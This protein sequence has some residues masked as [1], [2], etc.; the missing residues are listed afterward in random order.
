VKPTTFDEALD[1]V[2]EELPVETLDADIA[3]YGSR[4]R[5]AARESS[6]WDVF[7]LTHHDDLDGYYHA[8]EKRVVIKERGLD[9]LFVD[10]QVT[11]KRGW[12]RRELAAALLD[13]RWVPP[14]HPRR[15]K[16]DWDGLIAER[17]SRCQ[18]LA[19]DLGRWWSKM[20]EA[21]RVLIAEKLRRY[22]LRATLYARGAREILSTPEI[23]A[24]WAA[25]STAERI[26]AIE[27]YYVFQVDMR[28][29]VLEG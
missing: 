7:V 14:A 11:S 18:E 9:V 19:A 25:L 24:K 5:G 10:A 20:P 12:K 8:M 15:W 28:A 26:N 27:P 3:F 4:V 29:K 21:N 6:D 13:A 1:A 17:S 16:I 23:D 2:R 22:M